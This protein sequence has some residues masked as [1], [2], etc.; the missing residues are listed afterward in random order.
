MALL[1]RII[2]NMRELLYILKEKPF[3]EANAKRRR[4]QS[5]LAKLGLITNKEDTILGPVD[6]IG[7]FKMSSLAL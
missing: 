7:P 3:Y 1:N 2:R 6:S 4:V 5:A